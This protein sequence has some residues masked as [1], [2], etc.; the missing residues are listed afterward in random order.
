MGN[1]Q[2]NESDSDCSDRY[3]KP[4]PLL[5][6]GVHFETCCAEYGNLSSWQF[7]GG[8]SSFGPQIRVGSKIGGI[9]NLSCQTGIR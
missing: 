7:W 3:P 9:S 2:G 8:V 1:E 6:K 4:G 5:A